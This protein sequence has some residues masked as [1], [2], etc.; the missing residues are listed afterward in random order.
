MNK[1]T[2]CQ[3]ST[4]AIP[5]C[6]QN[7][8]ERIEYKELILVRQSHHKYHHDE[9]F[10]ETKDYIA[11]LDGVIFNKNEL[12][13]EKGESWGKAFIRLYENDGVNF[14]RC[15]RG[16][17]RGVLID[18]KKQ[19]Q[20]VFVD[21]IGSKPIYYFSDKKIGNVFSTDLWDIVRI[22]KESNINNEL[23]INSAYMMLSYGYM[24]QDNILINGVKKIWPGN[25]IELDNLDS[26]SVCYHQFSNEESFTDDENTI[27][28]NIDRLFT[29][30]VRRQFD[31]DL[32]YGHKHFV[33][34][35]GGLDSRMTSWVANSLG[36]TNQLNFTFSQS[37]YLD[38]T[39]PKK[40][41]SHFKA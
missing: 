16:T 24:V 25:Y 18:K 31:K 9:L 36:Y 19:K 3:H 10:F 33:G 39:I 20:I 41:A 23:N 7:Y 11:L 1:F 34:L 13:L 2:V 8:K 37:D 26:K 32:E 40:I 22:R 12:L 4:F 38:E 28:E 30:A 5:N 21:H 15:F 6:L 27:I 35:S 17:F 14:F 29:Q